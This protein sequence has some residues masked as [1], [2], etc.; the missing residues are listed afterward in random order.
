MNIKI[1][2]N[3]QMPIGRGSAFRGYAKKYPLLDMTPVSPDNDGRLVGDSFI[4]PSKQAHEVYAA[5]AILR[6]AG[7]KVSITARKE[8]ATTHRVWRLK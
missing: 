1:E 8:N 2:R 6:K 4:V 3:V 7:K 5:A